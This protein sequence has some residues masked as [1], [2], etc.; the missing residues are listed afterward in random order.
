MMAVRNSFIYADL[1]DEYAGGYL[2]LLSG[3]I[4][5]EV[6][7]SEDF[8]PDDLASQDG[9]EY[10]SNY[11][12]DDED[13]NLEENENMDENGSG[14]RKGPRNELYDL[15]LST[16]D[17]LL[18]L[19]APKTNEQVEEAQ[20][21]SRHLSSSGRLTRSKYHDI[22]HDDAKEVLQLIKERRKP[23]TQASNRETLCVVCQNAPR[24]VVLWPCRCFALCE[25]CRVALAYKH[26]KGCV[27][28]RREVDSFSRIFVP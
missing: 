27:C 25:E 17:Y 13:N 16:P 3:E 14:S 8:V 21:L 4:L 6:D 19:L 20:I 2:R 7:D 1:N 18:S 12:S 23:A 9:Y 15:V 22:H 10:A 5:P 26:F 24:Q 28:C 11:S